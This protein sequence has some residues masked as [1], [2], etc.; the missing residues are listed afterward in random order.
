LSR[1]AKK[2]KGKKAPRYG[3]KLSEETK[4]KISNSLNGRFRGANHPNYKH[5]IN[6]KFRTVWHSRFEYKEWRKSVYE[7][8]N[9]TCQMCDKPSN[10]DLQ[11]HHI[12]PVKDYPLLI[13]DI[14][15]GITL[16]EACHR[17]IKGKEHDYIKVFQ[18]IVSNHHPK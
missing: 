10:G 6:R 14:D 18:E 17:S 5:G 2:R 1:I 9:Y 7:R 4:R 13:V 15:N 16:C 12:L 8:D 11:C 3:A